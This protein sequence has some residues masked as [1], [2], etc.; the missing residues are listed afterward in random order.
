MHL[1][2]GHMF[3]VQQT[4]DSYIVLKDDMILT[5]ISVIIVVI[6]IYNLF[7]EGY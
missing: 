4:Y 3:R 5:E 2:I 7:V 1:K 6:I